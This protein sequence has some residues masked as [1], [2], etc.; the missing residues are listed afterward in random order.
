MGGRQMSVRP[1]LVLDTA[2]RTPVVALA[3]ERGEL[4][5]ERQWQSAHRHSEELLERLDDLLGEAGVERRA[6][7]GVVVGTGPGSFTGL[8]IGLATAKVV[9]YG[10]DI[11]L[12]GVS[13]T[14]AL[15]TAARRETGA[16]P[17]AVV[18]PAGASDSYV[19]VVTAEGELEPP[20]L[21]ASVA[22]LAAAVGEATLVAVDI[23]PGTAEE[24][25]IDIGRR[26][27]AGMAAALA[28]LGA[29]ALAEGRTAEPAELVPAYVA[30]PRGIARAAA[31]MEWSPD[32]R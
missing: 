24:A 15:A 9:A 32:L 20:R 8:R 13:T 21:V 30:L 31:E 14:G 1:L 28:E 3:D 17:I 25:A 22:D 4:I 5:G 19:H 23:D 11:P 27:V 7:A 6:L 12:V 10:V 18:L 2:T 26:A 16:D 29:R